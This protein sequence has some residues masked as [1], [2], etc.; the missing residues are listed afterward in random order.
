MGTRDQDIWEKY[1]IFHGF[2]FC[3]KIIKIYFKTIL[4]TFIFI[5]SPLTLQ[6]KYIY[7]FIYSVS[8]Q[9]L[10]QD[11]LVSSVNPL[12]LVRK[13]KKRV[14]LRLLENYRVY[15]EKLWSLGTLKE[16]AYPS[17]FNSRSLTRQSAFIVHTQQ[18]KI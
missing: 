15:I 2:F 16:I 7:L 3:F 6:P 10:T 1:D 17:F 12:C 13:Y 18:E 11:N 14:T 4:D 8:R 9:K 5:Y